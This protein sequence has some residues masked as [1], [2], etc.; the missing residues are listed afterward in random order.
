M[1][2]FQ[3]QAGDVPQPEKDR[4]HGILGVT[5]K[6][7]GSFLEGDL[8]DRFRAYFAAQPPVEPQSHHPAEPFPVM[9]EKREQGALHTRV[10][11]FEEQDRFA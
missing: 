5:G 11:P 8:Q 9:V 3:D 6:L 7:P 4:D 10:R 1:Y 2:A